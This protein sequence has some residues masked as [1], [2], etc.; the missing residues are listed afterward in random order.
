MLIH[1]EQAA[2]LVDR[3]KWTLRNWRLKGW[4]SAV[5]KGDA[6]FF[7]RDSLLAARERAERHY[8]DRRFVPGTGGLSGRV[9]RHRLRPGEDEGLW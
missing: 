9:R 2:K 7:D 8:R 6:W 5:K 1:A 4:V 3:S